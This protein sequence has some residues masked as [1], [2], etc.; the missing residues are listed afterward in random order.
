MERLK[1]DHYFLTYFSW[2]SCSSVSPKADLNTSILSAMHSAAR[3]LAFSLSEDVALPVYKM[4][5][6]ENR[7]KLPSREKKNTYI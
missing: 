4:K 2:F 5:E 3:L 7:N 1:L 6:I